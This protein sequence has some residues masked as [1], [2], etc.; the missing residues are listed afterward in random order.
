MFV[1]EFIL[2]LIYSFCEFKGIRILQKNKNQSN[3]YWRH[4]L[5]RNRAGFYFK[6]MA[7]TFYVLFF[8][9]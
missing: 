2:I 5:T 9:D 3:Y 1:Y 7:K 6:H 8:A 4:G